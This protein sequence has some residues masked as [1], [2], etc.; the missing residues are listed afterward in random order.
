MAKHK[1]MFGHQSM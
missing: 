1:H